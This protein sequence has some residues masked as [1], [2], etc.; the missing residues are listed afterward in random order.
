MA[1]GLDSIL[2]AAAA[3]RTEAGG[4]DIVFVFLGD[5]AEKKRLQQ[6]AA[7]M[8]LKS[9]I[10]LDTVPKSEVTRYWSLLDVSIIH[11]KKAPV[12]TTV[13]P[14]KLFES[15]AMGIPV[16]LGVAGELAALVAREGVGVAFEPENPSALARALL[17]M[18]RDPAHRAEL[19]RRCVAAAR[20]YDRT[21]LAADM[22]AAL[23][24]VA[25]EAG[26]AEGRA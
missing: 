17:D 16:L 22:L 8:D 18:K 12:F 2:A 19:S 6:K 11:L 9:V 1:H 23:K 15:M 5:G 14:S 10:F 21:A 3:L 13:I 7:A 4:G 25:G 20:R 26:Y 24:R